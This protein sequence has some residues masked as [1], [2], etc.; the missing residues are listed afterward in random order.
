M[1][2][3]ILLIVGKSGSGKSTIVSELEK[4][5]GL[6]S[7]QSYTTRKP[8]YENE[9]GHIFLNA[10]DFGNDF[11]KIREHYPNRVGETEYNGHLYFATEEQVEQ[12]QLYVIDPDGVDYFKQHYH[13]NKNVQIVYVHAPKW[14]LEERMRNRGDSEDDIQRRLIVDISF[15]RIKKQSNLIVM[16]YVLNQSVD[17][18][19]SYFKSL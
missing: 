13:G 18:I 5:Y 15:E 3:S 17:Q 10:E 4:R 14:L 7:I 12:C 2:N 11:K 9:P 6:K 8:R 19:Y 1:N 16:N